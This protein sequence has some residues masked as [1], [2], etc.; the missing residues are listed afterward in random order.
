MTTLPVLDL[1]SDPYERGLIHGRELS[2]QI[3][4]NV[5]TYLARTP[6]VQKARNGSA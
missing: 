3:T 6:R 5:D 4:E 1:G 2:R